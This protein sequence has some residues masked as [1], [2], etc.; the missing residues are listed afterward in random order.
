MDRWPTART[1]G[2]QVAMLVDTVEEAERWIQSG[3]QIIAYS[4]DVAVLLT[5]YR[6]AT[7]RLRGATR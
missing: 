2:K 6:S 7:D 4:S 1:H 5:A 3:V